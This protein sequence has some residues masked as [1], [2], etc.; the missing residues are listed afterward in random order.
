LFQSTR[1]RGAR[2]DFKHCIV[3]SIVSIHAP[4][5][6][7]TFGLIS[8]V[9][10][11]CFNPRARGGR[12]YSSITNPAIYSFQSTR[13][14]GARLSLD[15]SLQQFIVSIH[16]PAGGATISRRF[17]CRLFCFNPRARGGRDIRAWLLP[18][19]DLFQS[20][21]P[22]GA[23]QFNTSKKFSFP[24]SIHAPAGGAT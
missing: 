17:M 5:G 21:R 2:H 19:I 6:G 4:A 8:A 15:E 1:P 3:L 23:R 16:A 7:A 13:P 24:V 22:R 12:D 11:V 10:G 18:G 14:R 20:T 9:M